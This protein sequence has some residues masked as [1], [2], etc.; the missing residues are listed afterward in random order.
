MISVD[1]V[2]VLKNI[3]DFGEMVNP[4]WDGYPRAG[5]FS[6]GS[7][8]LPPRMFFENS[9]IGTAYPKAINGLFISVLLSRRF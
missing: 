1:A 2:V 7:A 9:L 4:E 3:A 5:H 6:C 8:P